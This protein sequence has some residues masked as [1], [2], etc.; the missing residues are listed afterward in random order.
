MLVNIYSFSQVVERLLSSGS[1]PNLPLGRGIGTALCCLISVLALKKR[2]LNNSLKIVSNC[3]ANRISYRNSADKENGIVYLMQWLCVYTESV[4]MIFRWVG[5]CSM[6]PIL[7][8]QSRW[9][10]ERD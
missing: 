3:Q 1:D 8:S 7:P 5:S 2:D 6:E 4:I 9:V 10:L